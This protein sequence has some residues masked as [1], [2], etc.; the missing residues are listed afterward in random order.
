MVLMVYLDVTETQVCQD[1][2]ETRETRDL[3]VWLEARELRE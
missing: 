1:Q 3:L 2:E